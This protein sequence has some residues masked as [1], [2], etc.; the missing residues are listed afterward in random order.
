MR[1]LDLGHL[2]PRRICTLAHPTTSKT[3][4]LAAPPILVAK[5]RTKVDRPYIVL[6]SLAPGLPNKAWLGPARQIT[7]YSLSESSRETR[8]SLNIMHAMR[9]FIKP[10]QHTDVAQL[11]SQWNSSIRWRPHL[12]EMLEACLLT[13]EGRRGLLEADVVAERAVIEKLM[14]SRE[15]SFN[16]SFVHGVLFLEE[17][18]DMPKR[19][20]V[21]SYELQKKFGFLRA[22]TEMHLQR[23]RVRHTLHSVVTRKLGG[24][25]LLLSGSV[26]SIRG[27]SARL[28]EDYM[29]FVT[30]PLRDGRYLIRP[31]HWKEWYMGAH[32]MGVGSLYLGIIDEAG[33][34]RNARL[35]RTHALPKAVAP[36]DP[37]DHIDWAFRALTE[38]RDYF[39]EAADLDSMRTRRIMDVKRS[40]WRVEI[41]PVDGEVRLV[42]RKL[43][44]AQRRGL[45]ADAYGLVPDSVIKAYEEGCP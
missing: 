4:F 12:P 28:P 29:Q 36:W 15:A 37:E 42:V 25:N 27:K 11:G 20:A 33:I 26:D 7:S 30:R 8:V 17:A 44:A 34:L 38:L 22:C 10:E 40:V 41:K 21:D 24:L 3:K 2:Q 19:H 6:S 31:K 39:Q 23:S 35:L 18:N 16:A 43:N 45:R 5:N 1:P 14:F 32:L 13:A 9:R